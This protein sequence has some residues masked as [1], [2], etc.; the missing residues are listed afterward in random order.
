[1]FAFVDQET[2]KKVVYQLPRVGVGVKYGLPQSRKT[3][4]MT[5]KQ[6]FKHS[7]MSIKWQKREISNFD[8]LMFLNTVAGR[9]FNDLSQYPVFPWI[10]TNYTSDSLDLS[11]ASNFR[12]LSKVGHQAAE[13]DLLFQPIGALSESRRK[14]FQERYSSW[15]DETIPA[16]HYGTHYS[17]QAFTLNWL[18]RVVGPCLTEE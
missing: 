13:A 8:Y 14:F 10:L 7:D 18:M 11:L 12:D 9:T 16:F 4:L 15:E 3:S 2:V 17:T 6:L 5:P 1:M